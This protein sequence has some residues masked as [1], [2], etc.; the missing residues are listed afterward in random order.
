MTEVICFTTAY[1]TP[2]CIPYQYECLRK[3]ITVTFIYYVFD[4]APTEDI[5][6]K[7]KD[8]A[9]YSGA[10]Y[11]RIPNNPY[12]GNP[13]GGA[14]YSVNFALQYIY[15]TLKYRGIAMC[16]DSDM[17][18]VNPFNPI[19][20]IGAYDFVG[21]EQHREHVKYY[22]NQLFIMNFKNI[23][24]IHEIDFLPTSID[25]HACDCGGNLYTFFKNNPDLSV[26]SFNTIINSGKINNENINDICP[27]H[28]KDYFKNELTVITPAFSEIYENIFLHYRAG[29]NWIG[30]SSEVVFKRSDLLYTF[31]CNK[32]IDWNISPSDSNKYIIS[33]VL[34][35]DSPKYTYN[36]IINALIAK[37]VYKGW[38]C[39]YYVDNTVPENIINTLKSF[40][41]VE[42]VP[43]TSIRNPA[44]PERMLWRFHPAS[45]SNVAAMISRDLDSWVSFRDAVLTKQWIDSDKGLHI[46]RDHCYHSQKIMGGMWGIKRDVFPQMKDLCNTFSQSDTYD[47][48]FLANTVYPVCI[49]NSIVHANENQKKMGGAP[50]IGYFPDDGIPF[51]KFPK[52]RHYIP[53]LDIEYVNAMNLFN[54]LHCRLM[55]PFFIGNMINNIPQELTNTVN[56]YIK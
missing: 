54:C 11:V 5:A 38:T 48:G 47:Q 40:D 50:A 28:F 8:M 52:I 55:H 39:R 34:Y 22:T 13:S 27:E 9:L 36:G 44:G 56:R 45:E 3:F 26:N 46:I 33:V 41:N 43:M 53:G 2:E 42:I 14:G 20:R 29:S 7:N 18:P 16:I 10:I 25:G 24:D 12:K 6:A 4:N 35:G 21:V 19:E 1:S 32:L 49:N 37:K 17:F 31:L 15:N 51:T 23:K 30:H